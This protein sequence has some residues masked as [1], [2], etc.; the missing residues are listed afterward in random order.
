MLSEVVPELVNSSSC[1]DK[2]H[3]IYRSKAWPSLLAI[4]I[5]KAMHEPCSLSGAQGALL[6]VKLLVCRK[7]K[8]DWKWCV[9]HW[10]CVC[11]KHFSWDYNSDISETTWGCFWEGW[12]QKDLME[13]LGVLFISCLLF[14]WTWK[15]LPTNPWLSQ[16]AFFIACKSLFTLKTK[17]KR[18][19]RLSA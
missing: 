3:K 5:L 8:S 19:G 13:A 7:E 9:S 14:F 10:G 16:L 6:K 4:S 12:R 17:L 18:Q 11:E 15:S 2:M 1:F